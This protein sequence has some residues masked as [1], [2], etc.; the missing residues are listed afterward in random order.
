MSTST[1]VTS[2]LE[3]P[4]CE[5]LGC[6]VPVFLPGMGARAA[7]GAGI[8]HC[9]IVPSPTVAR[10]AFLFCGE[11]EPAGTPRGPRS[12]PRMRPAV[13]PAF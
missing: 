12:Q 4:I 8:P 2:D 5:P 9:G 11:T 6:D 7:V 10:G 3:T 13:V 1:G